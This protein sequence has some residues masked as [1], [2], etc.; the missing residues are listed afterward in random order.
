MNTATFELRPA[1][2][3]TKPVCQH[4]G[5]RLIDERMRATGFCCSGCS[6]VYRLV[7]EH[8]LAGYYRIKDDIT[9]PADAAVFQARDYA[10]L[11]TA[12]RDAEAATDKTPRADARRP[13]YFLRRLRVADRAR[14]S[15]ATRRARHQCQRA[16]RHNAAALGARRILRRGIR[17]EAASLRLPCR[18]R[19]RNSGRARES[20]AREAY[21]T[22]HGVCDERHALLAAGVFRHGE[23]V[24]VGRPFRSA[25]AGVWHA[26]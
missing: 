19:G 11:E 9:T 8:G 13:G 1:G 24:R 20:R 17:E 21:R 3:A 7:H 10:W 26:E 22:L 18:C 4:C 15:T 6:Y 12:Q 16:I 14:V 23:H 2:A 5:A 25:F